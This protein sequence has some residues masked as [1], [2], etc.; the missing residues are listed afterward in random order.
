MLNFTSDTSHKGE[1]KMLAWSSDRATDFCGRASRIALTML[2]SCLNGFKVAVINMDQLVGKQVAQVKRPLSP[3]EA[4][5]GCRAVEEEEDEI[6]VV[7]PPVSWASAVIRINKDNMM[8]MPAARGHFPRKSFLSSARQAPLQH[9]RVWLTE[10]LI[11]PQPSE[12]DT[13]YA[14]FAS[15]VID[16]DMVFDRKR[17][18]KTLGYR[19]LREWLTHKSLDS[20]ASLWQQPQESD[21]IFSF[22]KRK[23]PL[24]T[25]VEDVPLTVLHKNALGAKRLM[26]EYWNGWTEFLHPEW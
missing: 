25:L 26:R 20:D 2:T 23:H 18:K 17:A 14:V 7:R 22:S 13:N 21:L 11:W 6:R 12:R 16:S 1:G 19:L 4:T 8:A 3:G 5:L 15:S 10:A 9:T 24:I